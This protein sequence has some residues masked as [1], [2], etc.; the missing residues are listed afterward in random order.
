VTA[1]FTPGLVWAQ[2]EHGDVQHAVT[3]HVDD[4]GRP[5]VRIPCLGLRL[6]PA[7]VAGLSDSPLEEVRIC[8]KRH[9][10]LHWNETQ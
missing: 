8:R 9:C 4:L 1:D 2:L 10:A 5:W 3:A 7:E 6:P